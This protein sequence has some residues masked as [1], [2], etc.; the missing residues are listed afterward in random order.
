M[1]PPDANMHAGHRQRV[2]EKI[3][4][5][6]IEGMA[7]HEVIEFLL[8]YAIPKRDVN[9][10]AHRLLD[11]FGSLAGVLSAPA[12]EIQAVDGA[13]AGVARVLRAF[14]E[15]VSACLAAED[16]PPVR[17]LSPEDAL[18]VAQAR[19][20]HPT[21]QE[22]AALCVAE[23]GVLLNCVVRDWDSMLAPEGARWLLGA[24]MDNHARHLTLI[25]KRQGRVRRLARMELEALNQLLSLLSAA[26][27]ELDDM[28]LLYRDGQIGLREAGV[29]SSEAA[30]LAE[31]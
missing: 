11:R 16:Q 9:P 23:D 6:G 30:R 29:L 20:V 4:T 18:R 26:E 28:I 19:F 14:G 31:E 2:R 21:R 15:V 13:G 10:L 27:I 12:E 8:F 22:L 25:W 1:C 5:T 3:F 17:V 24:A 7:D